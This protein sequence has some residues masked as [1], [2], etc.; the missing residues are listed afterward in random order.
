[1]SEGRK[2]YP[3]FW[4]LIFVTL[5]GFVSSCGSLP[6]PS[7]LE[8]REIQNPSPGKS[9]S[10]VDIEKGPSYHLQS[11]DMLII[12]VWRVP[13]LSQE[14][15]VGPDGTF[16]YPLL[17]SV[18]AEGKT[19]DEVRTYLA[20]TLGKS[21]LV[22][23]LVTVTRGSK[24]RG[25][26]VVGEVRNPGAFQFEER[27]NVYQAI[28]MAGGFTDFGSKHVKIIRRQGKERKVIKISIN[29]LEKEGKVDPESQIQP[30]DV[31]V[32]PKRLL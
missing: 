32:V 3:I 9:K 13:L 21:Y 29:K 30:G 2:L 12:D 1:M 4:L 24:S 27:I 28:I 16:L 31:I 14:V 15:T 20:E 6:N 5:A 11:G 17:G 26:Y 25:F 18:P 23:P 10:P 19:L 22:N 8:K 7:E